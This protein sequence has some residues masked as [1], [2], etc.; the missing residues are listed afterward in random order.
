MGIMK[1]GNFTKGSSLLSAKDEIVYVPY[2]IIDISRR[3]TVLM[4]AY[5][6][7]HQL[8]NR[9]YTADLKCKLFIA[10]KRDATSDEKLSITIMRIDN[11]TPGQLG[12]AA[13]YYKPIDRLW[14][15]IA[16]W[17]TPLELHL[18][19]PQ[20]PHVIAVPANP[21]SEIVQ[22]TASNPGVGPLPAHLSDIPK[23]IFQTWDEDDL[24]DAP[25]IVQKAIMTF[26]TLNRHYQHH[27][28]GEA[29]ARQYIAEHESDRVL[30]AYDLLGPLAYKSDLWRYVVLYHE[31]GVYADIKMIA[32]APLDYFL[33]A[34]GGALVNDIRGAGILNA[35]MALPPGDILMRQAISRVTSNVENRYY[36]QGALD[37]T[38]PRML[39]SCL[40]ELP[41]ET[42]QKYTRLQFENTGVLIK[43]MNLAV[44]SQHNG[45]YRRLLSRPGMKR[46]YEV[47]WL[48]RTV[49]GEATVSTN[50][51]SSSRGIGD[52]VGDNIMV[53]AIV[54]VLAMVL[55][56]VLACKFQRN[57]RDK[58]RGHD[59]RR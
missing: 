42:Q 1:T 51:D 47:P 57:N 25:R 10:L 46:H 27:L 33:P 52:Y 29:R 56:F 21:H 16:G 39:A 18:L 30:K 41:A 13:F 32:L 19:L 31:G 44:L 43:H 37:I 6:Y 5:D 49:Y 40:A 12:D 53:T 9:E 54:T 58:R 11:L 7:I 23:K 48:S 34:K 15:M 22:L 50:E 20:G 59:K 26:K 24:G 3:P 14:R 35:F 28:F 45:E 4:R 38:G 36:G 17:P 55:L 8:I 2:E